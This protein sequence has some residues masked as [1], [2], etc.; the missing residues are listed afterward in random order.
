LFMEKL[1]KFEAHVKTN[2]TWKSVGEIP[3]FPFETLSQI[4]KSEESNEVSI[5]VDYSIANQVAMNLYGKLYA[6]VFAI[7]AATWTWV[8][9]AAIVLAF[10]LG[11]YWLLLGVPIAFFSFMVSNPYNPVKGLFT[12]VNYTSI[13]LLIYGLITGAI[14]LVLFTIFFSVPFIVNSAM[15]RK[16]WNKLRG[17]ALNSETLFLY[18]F[19]HNAIGLQFNDTGKVLWARN[20]DK[21]IRHVG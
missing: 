11:N 13:A 4:R 15:Y 9:I 8:G 6:T 18:L 7:V 3:S 1:K 21:N 16:N 5:G 20:V 2:L 14:N 12:I 19:Q 10:I 17:L